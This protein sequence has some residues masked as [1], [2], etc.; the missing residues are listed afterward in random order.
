MIRRN[1]Q[2]AV[3]VLAWLGTPFVVAQAHPSSTTVELSVQGLKWI[4]VAERQFKVKRI[5]V[6]KYRYLCIEDSG[7]SAI[8]TLSSTVCSADPET[9]G[10]APGRLPDFEV[11]IRKGDLKILEAYYIR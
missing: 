6:S 7:E 8:I 2:L 1:R 3:T 9:R 10:N 11:E 5:D 4:H